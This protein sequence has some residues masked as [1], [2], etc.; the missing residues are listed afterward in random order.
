MLY[1]FQQMLRRV[2]MHSAFLYCRQVPEA[3]WIESSSVRIYWH[4]V[5]SVY[6]IVEI[7]GFMLRICCALL[8]STQVYVK[9]KLKEIQLSS[10]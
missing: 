7:C 1:L 4:K 9:A 8:Y 10:S 3:A 2:C 6:S 5:Y